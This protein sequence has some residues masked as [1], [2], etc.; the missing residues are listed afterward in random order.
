MEAVTRVIQVVRA[1]EE[2]TRQVIR[3]AE[4]ALR[5]LPNSSATPPAPAGPSMTRWAVPPLP[6][7]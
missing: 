7:W 1:R 5:R 6:A 3:D 2:I 4:R